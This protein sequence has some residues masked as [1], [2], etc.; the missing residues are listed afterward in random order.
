MKDEFFI[1]EAIKEAK[2]GKIPY[3]ALIVKNGRI[4]AKIKDLK[5]LR[6]IIS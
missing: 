2:K 5:V 4:L 1:R 3:A 6:Y